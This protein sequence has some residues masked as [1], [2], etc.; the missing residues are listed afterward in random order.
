[1]I[2]DI[3]NNKFDN[4]TMIDVGAFSGGTCRKFVLLDL[5]VVAFEPNPERYQHIEYLKKS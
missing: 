3:I 2:Y 5:N 1:M 4:G